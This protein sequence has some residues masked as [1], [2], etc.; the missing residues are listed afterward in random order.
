MKRFSLVGLVSVLGLLAAP[1]VASADGEGECAGGLCGTP[2]ESGGG[3]CGC[4]GG[5]SILIANTDLGDT[6]QYA[7]DYDE[8]GWEDDFDNCPFAFNR[9]QVD[10]D[11]DGFGD[12]CDLCAGAFDPAQLDADG[13]GQGDGCDADADGDGLLNEGD[14]CALIANPGQL[15]TDGDGLGNAC[16]LDD[17]QDGFEDL[18]D[19]CPLIA[20][21][22]NTLEGLD[23][24]RCDTDVDVDGVLDA[25][26]NCPSVVNPRQLDLDGDLAGDDCDTDRDGDGVPDLLDNCAGAANGDQLDADRDGLGEA[27]DDHFCYVVDQTGGTCLDPQAPFAVSAGGDV[28]AQTGQPVRLRIFANRQ[29]A[30]MRYT[31]SVTQAP[32]GSAAV[33][34][35]A[36]GAVAVSTP[37]E[38]HYLQDAV[39]KFTA[40]R[41]GEY[42]LSLHAE[43]AYGDPQ[44]KSSS[45]TELVVMAEGEAVDEAGGCATTGAGAAFLPGWAL[46]AGVL[47]LARRR[48]N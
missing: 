23:A 11:A 34:A 16:D 45:R 44:G 8:D 4:G 2:D 15:D 42:R 30:A 31:W 41:P 47:G 32:E 33:P 29:N 36:Q 20:T 24:A 46:L 43:L 6:Y 10:G 35:H 37:F 9:E 48:R 40:D 21:A 3:G 18:L 39:A 28:L 7:D 27:C 1:A 5:G 26:D 17:D 22:A 38:Y 14:N 13:D 19:R 12:A 25:R